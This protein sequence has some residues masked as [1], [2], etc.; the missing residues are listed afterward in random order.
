MAKTL[1]KKSFECVK[2]HIFRIEK[3][4]IKIAKNFA[5]NEIET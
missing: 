1:H 5:Q 2:N 3:E 4:N